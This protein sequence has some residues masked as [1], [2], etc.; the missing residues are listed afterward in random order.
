[1]SNVIFVILRGEAPKDLL[2]KR[3]S[4]PLK[5]LRMTTSSAFAKVLCF[6]QLFQP[7]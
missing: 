4:S 1:M 6:L 7:R 3:D 5:R 2:L